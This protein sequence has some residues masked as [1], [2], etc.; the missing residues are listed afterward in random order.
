MIRRRGWLLPLALVVS[1]PGC[2]TS[3]DRREVR[4][5]V[6][7]FYDAVRH[8]RG[9]AA[10]AALSNSAAQQLESQT[11]QQCDAVVTRLDYAGGAIV[12]VEVFAT[13]AKVDLRNGESAF[14]SRESVGWRLSAIGC[15]SKGKPR[16]RPFDCQVAA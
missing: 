5:V 15:A 3:D 12:R 1:L 14:L 10:C 13:S 11:L 8:D 16:D 6:Q 4:S 2:G 9:A 7:R